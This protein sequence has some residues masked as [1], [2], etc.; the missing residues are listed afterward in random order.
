MATTKATT[1]RNY[2]NALRFL[3]KEVKAGIEYSLA[4]ERA[5]YAFD[6]SVGDGEKLTSD[7]DYFEAQG[8]E[9]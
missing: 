3:Q 7:Y 6:L 4:H 2:T 1:V 8:T 9:I 5:C